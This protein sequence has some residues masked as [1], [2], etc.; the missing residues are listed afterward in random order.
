MLHR[1][2]FIAIAAMFLATQAKAVLFFARP[3]DPN[4]QRWIQRDP[5]AER[6]GLNLYGYV[7]NN[8]VNEVDPLGLANISLNVNWGPGLRTNPDRHSLQ[9]AMNRLRSEISECCKQYGIACGDTVSAQQGGNNG[10]RI[11]MVD[12][13]EVLNGNP[14]AIANGAEGGSIN[15]RI[16]LENQD[17]QVLAHELG[18]VGGHRDPDGGYKRPDGTMDPYHSPYNNNVMNPTANGATGVNKCYCESIAKLAK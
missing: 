3:Y 4:L 1:I 10:V 11:N 8:P 9:Q 5:I 15:W 14:K 6:G 18:H 13:S 7:G 2:V 12:K 17:P 16:N